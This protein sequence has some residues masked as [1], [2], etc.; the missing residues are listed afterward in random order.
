MFARLHRSFSLKKIR[1]VRLQNRAL[2][3]FSRKIY[4]G[5]QNCLR[6]ANRRPCANRSRQ[7]IDRSAKRRR[8]R[9]RGYWR[10]WGCY[11]GRCARVR[12]PRKIC[13]RSGRRHPGLH[14][15]LELWMQWIDFIVHNRRFCRGSHYCSREYTDSL[16][17]SNK[18]DATGVEPVSL[19]L[20][21]SHDSHASEG[22]WLSPVTRS[23][24]ES[25]AGLRLF[26]SL[27]PSVRASEHRAANVAVN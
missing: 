6:A 20:R 24:T 23:T 19:T 1:R 18:M 15:S 2:I 4:R 21:T 27:S 25:S 12:H 9:C 8:R 16:S 17:L 3:P 5:R 14:A 22:H 10:F 26:C 7:S 11:P 13:K